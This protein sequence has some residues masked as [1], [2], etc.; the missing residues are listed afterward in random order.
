MPFRRIAGSAERVVYRI[1]GLP[2]AIGAVLESRT[3]EKLDPLRTAFARRF[4]HP[5]GVGEWLELIVGLLA[6]PIAVPLS[7]AWFTIRNGAVIERRHG[8]SLAAQFI[9][10]L[11]LYLTTGTLP[12]WYYVFELHEDGTNRAPTFIQRFETKRCI[13]PLLKPKKGSPLNDKARFAKYCAERGLRSV[14][15]LIYLDGKTPEQP[16]PDEDLF[17]KHAAGR[18]G[19][20]AQRWDRVAPSTFAG[21]Q[22]EQLSGSDLL[23]RLVRGSRRVPTIVQPR[24]RPHHSLVDVT[25]GALPTLRLLTCL[26]QG[27]ESELIDAVFRMSIGMNKTVDNLH[28]GG[29]AAAVDLASGRLSRATNLGTDARLGWLSFHPDTKAPIESRTLPLWDEAKRLVTFAHQEFADR[30]IIGWDVAI[31]DDGPVIVEGNGNPDLDIHQR[32]MRTGLR[33]HRFA[34]LIAY[35]LQ[36]AKD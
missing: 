12:P 24:L 16:F 26:N 13:F 8:K 9:E 14:K 11:K 22:G 20:G 7:S 29:I 32:F 25:A 33:R 10:Q 28:A 23:A 15:T 35:H 1:A 30:V 17:I 6:W 27:G 4:W 34:E 19:R 2:P 21:P 31:L 18:G 3:Y 36:K 5:D